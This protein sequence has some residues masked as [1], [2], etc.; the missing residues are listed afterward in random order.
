MTFTRQSTTA[1]PTSHT[2]LVA[3]GGIGPEI[4]H[5]QLFG[6]SYRTSS[7]AYRERLLATL[8]EI[9]DKNSLSLTEYIPLA[10]CNR[11]EVYFASQSPSYI[12]RMLTK[13][14]VERNLRTDAVYFKYDKAVVS[15]LF[16]VAAGMD[17]LVIGEEQILQQVKESVKN[18]KQIGHANAVLYPLF[19]SAIHTAERLRKEYGLI[20]T[21]ES[22]SS[23]A[24]GFVKNILRK[25]PKSAL[26]IGSGKM[27]RLALG[28]LSRMKIYLATGRNI[29]ID[30]NS[31]QVISYD[32]I[33][34]ILAF[35]DVVI[36]ASKRSGFVVKASDIPKTRD[37]TSELTIIDLGFPRNI[38]PEV[39]R[40]QNVRL[41]NI[42]DLVGAQKIAKGDAKIPPEVLE[43]ESSRFFAWLYATKLSRV[44]AEFYKWANELRET[45]IKIAKNRLGQISEKEK[46][47]IESLGMRLMNKLVSPI[48]NFVK[49]DSSGFTQEE[50]LNLLSKIFLDK[51]TDGGQE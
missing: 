6:A 19:E 2:G 11:V 20:R 1:R 31:V 33:P 39:S 42:D 29:S 16:R 14:L 18:A 38:D 40:A 47:V 5:L 34:K 12:R 28:E 26:L 46:L 49:Q 27:A 21:R 9:L 45:E 30:S 41:F 23:Y 24:V 51:T 7:I 17:S 50:K 22:I 8:Q 35:C 25:E 36:S 10:T 37:S 3:N 32:E 44:L 48:T 13:R 4:I 43:S 15:H